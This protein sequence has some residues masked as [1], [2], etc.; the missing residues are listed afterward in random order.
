MA[1]GGP[2]RMAIGFAVP[3]G[4]PSA[5][6]YTTSSRVPPRPAS[7]FPRPS[8]SSRESRWMKKHEDI[9][10]LQLLLRR[11]PVAPALAPAPCHRTLHRFRLYQQV[12]VAALPHL[13]ALYRVPPI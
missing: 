6:T 7:C 2:V 1:G 5:I 9:M 4:E 13:G 8:R 11:I 12:H 3:D 10:L